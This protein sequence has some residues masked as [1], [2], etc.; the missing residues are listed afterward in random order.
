MKGKSK[1]AEVDDEKVIS[2]GG[3]CAFCL[4]EAYTPVLYYYID[5]LGSFLKRKK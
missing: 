2:N 1:F 5:N 3:T 4:L